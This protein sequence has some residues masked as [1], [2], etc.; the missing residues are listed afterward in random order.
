[1]C[2][3]LIRIQE[4]IQVRLLW[5]NYLPYKLDIQECVRQRTIIQPEEEGKE[6]VEYKYCA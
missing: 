6:E 5:G 2:P 3:V 4:R 1:M